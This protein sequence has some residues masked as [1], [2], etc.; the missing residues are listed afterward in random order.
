M[1]TQIEDPGPCPSIEPDIS[2][3]EIKWMNQKIEYLVSIGLE[4]EKATKSVEIEY[5]GYVAAALVPCFEQIFGDLDD[6]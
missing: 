1:K 3:C 4:R 6:S 5:M 2:D